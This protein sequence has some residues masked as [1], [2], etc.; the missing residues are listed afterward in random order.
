[1]DYSVL[2][3]K[4]AA[5]TQLCWNLTFYDIFLFHKL[6][7]FKHLNRQF[8][9]VPLLK[10]QQKHKKQKREKIVKGKDNYLN[11]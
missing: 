10:H 11:Y 2:G 1:M 5:W 4:N 7:L 8:D 9:N 6:Q 3:E